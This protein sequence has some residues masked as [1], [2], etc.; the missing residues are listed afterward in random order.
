MIDVR[1]EGSDTYVFAIRK[2]AHGKLFHLFPI[3]ARDD[4]VSNVN[5]RLEYHPSR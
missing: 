4:L 3:S 5:S 1:S 2:Q